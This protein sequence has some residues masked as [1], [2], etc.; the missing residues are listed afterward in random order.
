MKFDNF[1]R[2]QAESRFNF[3]FDD[4]RWSLLGGKWVLGARI[5]LRFD[6][7]KWPIDAEVESEVGLRIV[8]ECQF[9]GHIRCFIGCDGPFLNLNLFTAIHSI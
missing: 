7:F 6:D 5:S 3:L 9:L 8:G 2:L 4:L 1:E